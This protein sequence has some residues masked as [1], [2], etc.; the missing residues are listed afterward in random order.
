VRK[1]SNVSANVDATKSLTIGDA[2][3]RASS[4]HQLLVL[5]SAINEVW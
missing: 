3:C 1:I 5:L 4:D 2:R